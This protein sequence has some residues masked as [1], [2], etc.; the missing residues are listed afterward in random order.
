MAMTALATNK[1]KQSQE[2]TKQQSSEN[3]LQRHN[4]FNSH[5]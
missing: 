1:S 2:N 4:Y 3:K 5:V